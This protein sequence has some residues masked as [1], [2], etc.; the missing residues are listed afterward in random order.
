MLKWNVTTGQQLLSPREGGFLEIAAN[1]ETA[2]SRSDRNTFQ[3]WQNIEGIFSQTGISITLDAD[4]GYEGFMLSSDGNLLA[5]GEYWGVRVW[6]WSIPDQT[7]LFTFDATPEEFAAHDKHRLAKPARF[8]GP[9][10]WYIGDMAFSPDGQTLAVSTG[11]HEVTLWDVEDGSL[12]QRLPETGLGLAFSPDGK[13]LASW[14]H[15][16]QQRDLATGSSLNALNDHVGTVRDVAFVPGR[17]LLAIGSDDGSVYLRNL[18][19]GGVFTRYEKCDAGIFSVAVS[20]D[21]NTVIAGS[22]SKLCVW[23]LI[24][25]TSYHMTA[26]DSP[27]GVSSVAISGDGQYAATVSH[28]DAVRLWQ[29]SDGTMLQEGYTRFGDVVAFS[30]VEALLVTRDYRDNLLAL[31]HVPDNDDPATRQIL[32]DQSN[33]STIPESIT[34]SPDGSLLAIG[35]NDGRVLVW[36]IE[37]GS[38]LYTLDEHRGY[39][40]GVAFSPDG[41][42]LAT[43]SFDQT[44]KLWRVADGAL[45][46]TVAVPHGILYEVAFSP[47][48]HFLA[49]GSSDGTVRLWGIP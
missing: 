39:V 17:D 9:G 21:G 35:S 8:S 1:G 42:L 47:D 30:P 2:V 37:D 12:Q 19:D 15:T 34:F 4:I 5:I 33:E 48:G 18:S 46:H 23:S 43:A 3:Q 14:Q 16:L 38:L 29:L 45:L 7:L 28:D 40:R 49:T 10:N 26:T 36:R 41:Q 13:K 11:F 24:D 31:W 20:P 27:W 44:I 32:N 6:L 25:N 22:H